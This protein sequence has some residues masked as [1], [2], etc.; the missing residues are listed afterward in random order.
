MGFCCRV[1]FRTVNPL[2]AA[3]SWGTFCARLGR[4]QAVRPAQKEI[5]DRAESGLI[6]QRPRIL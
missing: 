5:N 2:G 6:Y 1:R 3:L 4:L